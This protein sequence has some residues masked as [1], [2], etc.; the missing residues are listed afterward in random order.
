MAEKIP[1]WFSS[2]V[3]RLVAPEI[4]EIV[5]DELTVVDKKLD[6]MGTQISAMGLQISALDKK[7]EAVDTKLDALKAEITEAGIENLIL[8]DRFPSEQSGA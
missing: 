3:K 7:I 6:A 5:K 2:A 8:A 1:G 4:R